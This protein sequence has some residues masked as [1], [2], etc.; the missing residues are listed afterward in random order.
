MPSLL[1][2]VAQGC[3]PRFSL[4]SLVIKRRWY[5]GIPNPLSYSIRAGRHHLRHRQRGSQRRLALAH[6]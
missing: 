2:V 5:Q 1:V 4:L 6:V 3:E